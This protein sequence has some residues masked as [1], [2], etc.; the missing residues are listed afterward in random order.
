MAT[1]ALLGAGFTRNWGGW[2][3]AELIGELCGRLIDRPHLNQMLR[4]SG[5]FE[6]VLGARRAVAER[7]P[8][9]EQ[10]VEDVPRLE[11]AILKS[12]ATVNAALARVPDLRF[13][14]A[15]DERC[16]IRR[17]LARFDAIFTLNQDL[18]LELHY[19]GMGLES[20]GQWQHY[21]FPGIVLTRGWLRARR[22]ERNGQTLVVG[23]VPVAPAE[24][25]Q[26]VFKL[27]G[28]VNWRA[29]DGGRALVVG[30]GKEKAIPGSELLQWYHEQ[31]RRYLSEGNTKIMVI[32]YGFTDQH[33]NSSLLQAAKQHSLA[34]YLVDP[35][36]REALVGRPELLL[37]PLIGMC[38]RRFGEI[39][40]EPDSP[41]F[42]SIHRF[43][44]H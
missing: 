31:F 42:Q 30:T 32:G 5:D 25:Y 35:R 8:S 34:M 29:G 21:Y 11:E 43:F 6:Y 7:E 37:I 14:S 1:I 9:N 4:L 24:R 36:G 33:V 17:F 38:E 16:S 40:S 13:G 22:E 39:F 3:A 27:H 44:D 20:G 15:T 18:L 12:F 26:P 41:Q 19:D 10:A 23:S 28:S 2:L